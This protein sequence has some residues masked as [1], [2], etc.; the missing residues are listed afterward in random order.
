MKNNCNKNPIILFGDK[1][2]CCGCGSCINICPKN[3][4][5]MKDDEYGFNYPIIDQNKCIRCGLCKKVCAYQSDDKGNSPIAV[6]A[7]ALKESNSLKRSASGGVFFEVAK[8]ILKEGGIV[9]GCSMET[10]NNNLHPSHIIIDSEKDLIKLQGSKYVQSDTKFVFREIEKNLKSGI[11]V[12]FSGT[13]CQNAALK[14]YLE[15]KEYDNLYLIDIICHGVPSTSIFKD[16]ISFYNK[17]LDGNIKGFYFRDKS[18]GWGLR[19][20]VVY[21][22]NGKELSKV[23]PIQFSSYY[24]LFLQSEIYRENCYSCKYANKYRFSDLTL[25]DFWGIGEVHPEYLN[26]NY[27]K[28]DEEKGISCVLVNSEKGMRLMQC[29]KDNIILYESEFQKVAK[30]NG[31]LIQPSKKGKNRD[32]LLKTYSEKGYAGLDDLY[33]NLLG[34]KKYI[35]F[36]WNLIPYKIR[37]LI[38]K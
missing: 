4:I 18:C 32:K 21:K 35:Y 14:K 6:Y 9:I 16:Y 33:Y 2:Q 29:I 22:K 10:E 25:G 12:L 11:K 34:K 15:N 1:P 23:L 27:G 36:V 37:K 5:T 30:N 28:L 38:K 24:A 8:T 7:A 20:R 13:P 3:A 19:A 31:Q 26:R 17:K